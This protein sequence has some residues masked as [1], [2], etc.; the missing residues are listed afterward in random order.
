[1]FVRRNEETMKSFRKPSTDRTF[2]ILGLILAAP[3]SFLWLLQTSERFHFNLMKLIPP[4]IFHRLSGLYCPGC[5]GTRAVKALMEGH[6]VASFFHHPFVL[7]CAVL[8][9]LFM[10]SH[11]LEWIAA[12][13]KISR[14]VISQ[15]S[16]F[17]IKQKKSLHEK[18]LVKGL[19]FNIRYVYIG[20]ILI[21]VQWI[22]KNLLAIFG[23]RF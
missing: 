23:F 13:K 22:V 4:C 15:E 3:L 7:Y 19:S 11:T 12:H 10:I 14:K 16:K 1:M 21:L 20:V 18:H 9:A 8:Y 6:F 17:P 2:Y 5:G